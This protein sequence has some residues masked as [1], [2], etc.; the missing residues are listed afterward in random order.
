LL[1]PYC[2]IDFKT[3]AQAIYYGVEPDSHPHRVEIPKIE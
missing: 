2:M 3:I 1:A